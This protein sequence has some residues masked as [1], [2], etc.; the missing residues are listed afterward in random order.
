MTKAAWALSAAMALP[1]AAPAQTLF[2]EIIA[3]VNNDVIL[4]SELELQRSTLETALIEQLEGAELLEAIEEG[5]ANLLRDMIDQSLLVQKAE[6]FG[7]D[8]DLEVVRTMEQLRQ[9]YDFETLEDLEAAIVAQGDSVE[10]YREMI[11]T[12]YVAEVLLGQ[13]AYRQIIITTEEAREYYEANTEEFDS[14]PGVRIQEIVVLKDPN[15]PDGEEKRAKAEAALARV[16]DG[17]DFQEVAFEESEVSTAELGGDLGFFETGALSPIY[18]EPAADLGRNE[19]SEIID[20][21]DA[22]L[23]LKLVDR[24]DGGI[25]VFELAMNEIQ[26]YLASLE[27]PEARRTYIEELRAESFIEVKDGYVDTGAS[28]DAAASPDTAASPDAGE[29]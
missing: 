18:A 28:P 3:V 8:G 29:E 26:Q 24:H 14:P 20:L 13:E 12:R 7:I 25:R 22:Y 4:K 6:E 16:R 11:R 1:P 10:E 9:D 17:E 5:Q 19:V 2:D 23:I 21:P 15:D 27:Y